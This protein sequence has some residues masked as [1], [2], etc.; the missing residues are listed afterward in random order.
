MRKSLVFSLLI[1]FALSTLSITVITAQTPAKE[2]HNYIF[3]FSAT[4]YDANIADAVEYIFKKMVK[5]EDR[6]AL[7]TPVKSYNYSPKTLASQSAEKLINVTQN[8]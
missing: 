1:V 7:F 8:A 2:G 4:K 5:P 3:I 6:V